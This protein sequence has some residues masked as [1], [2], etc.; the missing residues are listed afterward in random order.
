[1]RIGEQ[2]EAV[3]ATLYRP[4]TLDPL[5]EDME[6]H[7]IRV[8]VIEGMYTNEAWNEGLSRVERPYAIVSNDD[9]LVPIADEGTSWLDRLHA[10]HEAGFTWVA[11]RP[12]WMP[13]VFR[14]VRHPAPEGSGDLGHFFS[15]NRSVDVPQVPDELKIAYGDNWFFEH[16]RAAGRCC[17][18]LDIEIQTGRAMGHDEQS[19]Y[20]VCRARAEGRDVDAVQDRDQVLA[21]GYFEFSARG[22]IAGLRETV[23]A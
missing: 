7:G 20:S 1:M 10:H 4:W 13:R 6:S 19:G 17:R 11:P 12:Y 5:V 9:I 18:A 16:H 23:D 2:Y 14:G 15:M 3:I 22:Y 21:K 8:H